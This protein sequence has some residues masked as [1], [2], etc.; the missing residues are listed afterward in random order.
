MGFRVSEERRMVRDTA[1]KTASSF[2]HD[3]YMA[4]STSGGDASELWQAMVEPGFV[5]ANTPTEYGGAGMDPFEL[6]IMGE[7]MA[8]GW[9]ALADERDLAGDRGLHP[10]VSCHA[11][12]EAGVPAE[13]GLR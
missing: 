13:D 6:A 8:A 3:Y 11:G 12:A 10:R 9:A 4:E 7:E 2:G 1:P 5:G